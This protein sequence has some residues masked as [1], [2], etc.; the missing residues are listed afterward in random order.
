MQCVLACVTYFLHDQ[1]CLREATSGDYWLPFANLWVRTVIDANL[2]T[3]TPNA[4]SG[5][6]TCA[7]YT[8]H[9]TDRCG[10][11]YGYLR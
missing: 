1:V 9:F 8:A 6:H 5:F 7:G 2:P 3:V 10:C 11:F 4:F